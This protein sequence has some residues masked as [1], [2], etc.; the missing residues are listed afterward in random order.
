MILSIWTFVP[1]SHFGEQSELVPMGSL[2]RVP[3]LRQE[4]A[5]ASTLVLSVGKDGNLE[6]EKGI[7]FVFRYI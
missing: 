1:L 3:D 4:V 7:S 2:L 5:A 6:G